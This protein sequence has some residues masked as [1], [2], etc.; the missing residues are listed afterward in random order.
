M[1]LSEEGNRVLAEIA[2]RYN[3]SQSA[4]EHLF[5]AVLFGQ[6]HQAQFNHPDLGGMGQW[7]NGGM[8]MIGDMFNGNLKAKVADICAELAHLSRNSNLQ[9]PQPAS[10]QAHYQGD[11]TSLFV[12]APMAAGNWWPETLGYAASTGAQNDL[13]YAFFPS[14]HRLAISVGGNVTIYDTGDHQIGGFSQQQSGDQSLTF[15]SQ[16]GLVRVCDLQPVPLP[17]RSAE[18]AP[19]VRRAPP[20]EAVRTAVSDAAADKPSA[21]VED[22]IFSEIER[23]AGL[24]AKGILQDEEFNAKKRELLDRL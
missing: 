2:G 3:V 21:A 13:R 23:L 24:H 4:V 9:Q 1:K 10:H 19:E 17:Q 8:T 12:S 5:A 20:S 14:S 22:D 16:H 6:G 15:T 18:D 11:M 7:S